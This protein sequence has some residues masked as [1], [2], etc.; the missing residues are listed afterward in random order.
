MLRFVLSRITSAIP[1]LLIVSIV[2]F[3]II[4]LT[5]GDPAELMLDEDATPAQ[6]AELRAKMGLD[7]PLPAQYAI[8]LG[9]VVSGDFGISTTTEKPVLDMIVSRFL[10]SAPIV[11]LALLLATIIAVPVGLLAAWRQNTTV[12]LSV[13]SAMILLMSVPGFWLGLM[14]LM[15]FG[16]ILGWLPVVGFVSLA[17]DVPAALVYMIM[18]VATLMLTELGSLTR[19]T[20]ASTISVARLEYITHARAKGLS[21]PQIVWRHALRNSFAPTWT[22]IGLSLGGLLGGVAITETVFTIPGLGRLLVDA[23]Y[24]RDYPVVQGCI[25]LITFIYVVVNLAVDLVYPLLDPRV[26]AS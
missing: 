21:E 25:L 7:Q 2:V 6:V 22:L 24:G 13:V 18:P 9:N 23:I 8:W 16:L 19:M 1:T 26:A 14:I 5:P 10:I 3:A 4:R 12:D 20:R 11:V 15:V 17:K